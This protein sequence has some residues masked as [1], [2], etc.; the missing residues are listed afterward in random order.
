MPDMDDEATAFAMPLLMPAKLIKRDAAG[1]DVD[2]ASKIRA[3][4]KK[5]RVSEQSMLIRIGQ[6]MTMNDSE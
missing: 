5:Y 2:D 1:V 6:V 3:L 4:A